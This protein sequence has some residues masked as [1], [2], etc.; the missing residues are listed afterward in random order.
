MLIIIIIIMLSGE[1]FPDVHNT[2][3][4]EAS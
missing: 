2:G 4:R 1:T 3:F